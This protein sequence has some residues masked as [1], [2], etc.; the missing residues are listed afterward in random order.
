M[1]FIFFINI[2]ILACNAQAIIHKR[3]E[4]FLDIELIKE[5]FLIKC[6][7]GLENSNAIVGFHLLDEDTYYYSYYRRVWPMKEC[8]QLQKDYMEL[9]ENNN[10]V[11]IVLI[12][13]DESLMIEKRRKEWPAPFNGAKKMISGAFIRLQAGDKCKAYFSED[14]DLQKNYWGGVIPEK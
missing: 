7:G 4:Y 10:T 1:R 8:L 2:I 5:Q 14:C 13:P 12:H 11:R 6:R 9:L 3:T